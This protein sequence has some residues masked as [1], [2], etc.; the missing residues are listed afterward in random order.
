MTTVR[1]DQLRWQEDMGVW[2]RRV[3]A[4]V[5]A[6]LVTGAL[7]GGVGSRF[8]MFVLRLTSSPS[9]HG[10]ETDDGFTMGT[11]SAATFFLLFVCMVA[12]VGAGLAYMAVRSWFPERLRS[13][14]AGV[15]GG[16][17]GGSLLVHPDGI[18]FRVLE[19]RLL[20]IAFF[21]AIPAAYGV[22]I[23]VIAER[24]LGRG[25]LGESAKGAWWLGLL[26]LLPLL[27]L[28]PFG[29][30][31]VVVTVAAWLIGR[32]VPG[33]AALWGSAPVTWAGRILLLAIAA[34]SLVSLVRDVADI[35]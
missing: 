33:A 8:A 3:S 17:V 14:L 20:A 2:G 1:V 22:F 29:I 32:A 26:P 23:S 16:I 24:R 34:A 19:P 6:G 27:L 25:A 21:V 7:V 12:G 15:F 31:I 5:I 35:L 9:L 4:G 28:G 30:V 13:T 11:F 10:L 18:D